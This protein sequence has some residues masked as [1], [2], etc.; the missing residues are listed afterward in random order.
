MSFI[1]DENIFNFQRL[2]FAFSR[3]S[4][5]EISEMIKG[6]FS[7]FSIEIRLLGSFANILLYKTIANFGSFKC[8]GKY[9]LHSI[10]FLWW[11]LVVRVVSYI[12]KHIITSSKDQISTLLLYKLLSNITGAR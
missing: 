11:I 10:S 6:C 1:E 8:L 4:D 5:P 7:T 12:I 9:A 3:S 2:P